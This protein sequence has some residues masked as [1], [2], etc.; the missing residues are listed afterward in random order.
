MR[1]NSLSNQ[2]LSFESSWYDSFFKKLPDKEIK[3]S[4]AYNK[5]G[6]ALASPHWNRV[7]LGVA[8]ITTQPAI[9]YFNPKVDK[10]TATASA[11]RTIAKIFVCT[12][13]GFCV[14]GSAYK[15]IEK[16]AHASKKEGATFFTPNAILNEKNLKKRTE[17]LKLHKNALSTV[18]A[19]SI[20][21][22]TNILIDAPLTT[23]AA[24]FL[25]AKYHPNYKNKEMTK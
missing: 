17:M 12:S 8:A 24:N 10:D 7:T 4:E 15:L 22:F 1:I 11:L 13:V 20:M 21:F 2:N 19:L 23:K 9:D 3:N 16:Y 25:I 5:L 14:R 18:L 6:H